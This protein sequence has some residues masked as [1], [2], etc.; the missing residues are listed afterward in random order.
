MVVVLVVDGAFFHL[1]GIDVVEPHIAV[2]LVH[3]F[4]ASGLHFHEV[5]QKDVY[6]VD[7]R[8][9][10]F[11][12]VVGGSPRGH[13]RRHLVFV[14]VFGEVGADAHEDGEVLVF[15]RAV[16]VGGFGMDEHLEVFVLSQV[17]VGGLVDG[18]SVAVNEVLD[19]H[20]Q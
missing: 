15:E 9:D 11:L 4:V 7:F 20:L 16:F 6:V 2:G 10:A 18:A 14:V 8:P 12:V 5:F 3:G 1:F 13:F 17:E 19:G